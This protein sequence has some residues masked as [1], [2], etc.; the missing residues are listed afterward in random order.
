MEEDLRNMSMSRSV[1]NGSQ[2]KHS[3]TSSLQS[4]VLTNVTN[5]LDRVTKTAFLNFKFRRA[6]GY[7]ARTSTKTQ[8]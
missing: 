3:G 8:A 5:L 7:N 1:M 4:N 6:D 2:E